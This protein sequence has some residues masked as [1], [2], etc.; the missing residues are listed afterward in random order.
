M[1]EGGG[2]GRV[3]IILL[4]IAVIVYIIISSGVL[5]NVPFLNGLKLPAIEFK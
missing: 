2:I 1:A 4:L 3:L 5:K